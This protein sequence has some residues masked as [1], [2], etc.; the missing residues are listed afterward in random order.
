MDDPANSVGVTASLA[1]GTDGLPVISHRDFTAGAL[2]VTHCGNV[3]CT[4][5]NTSTTVDDPA[6]SV[7]A[8]TSLAIGSD[9]LPVIS[10]FDSTAGA[11]RVTKCAS[12]TCQ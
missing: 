11:L 2:R 1:I 7:G 9:G 3:A 6:N 4:N 10:H 8:T 12:R 5:G